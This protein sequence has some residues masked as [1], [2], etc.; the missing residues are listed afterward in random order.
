MPGHAVDPAA[1]V[2]DLAALVRSHRVGELTRDDQF[3]ALGFDSLDRLALAVAVEQAT[4]RA[5]P[6]LVLSTAVTLGDL[7]DHLTTATKGTS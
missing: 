6:D 5:V 1:T 7:I 3:D 2:L 4:G